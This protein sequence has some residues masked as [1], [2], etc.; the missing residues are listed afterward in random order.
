[1][2]ENKVWYCKSDVLDEKKLSNIQNY[3]A[4]MLVNFIENNNIDKGV[5]EFELQELDGITEER[6]MEKYLIYNGKYCYYG[7]LYKFHEMQ[8][9]VHK[10]RIL[11]LKVEVEDD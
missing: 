10:F 6:E 2:T 5:F 11:V 1:M 7:K 9:I 4:R 8:E 3:K